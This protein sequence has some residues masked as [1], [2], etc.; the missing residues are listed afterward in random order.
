M[1]G[2]PSSFVAQFAYCD[3][4]YAA[5]EFR[6]NFCNYLLRLQI[7]TLHSPFCKVR[8]YSSP[9]KPWVIVRVW[10]RRGV[11]WSYGGRIG[12]CLCSLWKYIGVLALGGDVWAKYI[13]WIDKKRL[14]G[15]KRYQMTLS[16]SSLGIQ[17]NKNNPTTR[18]STVTQESL[19]YG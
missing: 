6:I 13:F 8:I 2:H 9:R 7:R 10:H 3:P 5:C 12:H 4:Y 1:L 18:S 11:W 14:W 17:G 19:G 16:R 15:N